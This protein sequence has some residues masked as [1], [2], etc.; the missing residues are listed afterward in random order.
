MPIY[1]FENLS[2]DNRSV[3]EHLGPQ[4][5][6]FFCYIYGRRGFFP[7]R[8]PK[9]GFFPSVLILLG[10]GGGGGVES[11]RVREFVF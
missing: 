10:G 6:V 5:G 4:K 11:S 1:G 8:P 3:E 9:S 2:I 7:P